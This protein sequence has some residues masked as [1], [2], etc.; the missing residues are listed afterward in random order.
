MHGMQ[1]N[2]SDGGSVAPIVFTSCEMLDAAK[3]ASAGAA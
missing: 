1:P 2:V 3:S